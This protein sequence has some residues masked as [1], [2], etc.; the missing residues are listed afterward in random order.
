VRLE[1]S[2]R[3]AELAE[4]GPT[5]QPTV[6]FRQLVDVAIAVVGR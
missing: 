6:D 3:V 4:V 1:L 5:R 2:S